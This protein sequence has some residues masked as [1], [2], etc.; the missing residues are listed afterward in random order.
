MINA[1]IVGPKK[2]KTQENNNIAKTT[3]TTAKTTTP[4]IVATKSQAINFSDNCFVNINLNVF[5]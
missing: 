3:T 1:S 4:A 2:K 5:A